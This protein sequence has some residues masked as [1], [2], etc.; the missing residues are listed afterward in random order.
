MASNVDKRKL[1]L[2]DLLAFMEAEAEKNNERFEK[3]NQRLDEIKALATKQLELEVKYTALEAAH[4]ELKAEHIKLKGDHYNLVGIVSRFEQE[5]LNA[6]IMVRGVPELANEKLHD[7]IHAIIKLVD[8]KLSIKISA[9]FR[10]GPKVT[11]QH[12]SIL[13]KLS[14]SRIKSQLL[15]AKRKVKV[16]CSAVVVNGK[17]IGG[18]GETVYFGEHLASLNARTFYIARQLVK[19]KQ[20][21]HAFTRNG[22]VWVRKGEGEDAQLVTNESQFSDILNPMATEESETDT[23]PESG[24]GVNESLQILNE[25]ISHTKTPRPQRKKA[26]KPAN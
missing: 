16:D 1:T 11:G 24:G 12:R 21:L 7:V 15:A 17:A 25:C 13:V 14:S 5:P 26:K 4:E 3:S 10:V 20:L 6:N 22:R 2:Q 8:D 23:V 18:P 9:A 19:K